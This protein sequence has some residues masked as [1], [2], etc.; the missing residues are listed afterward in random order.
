MGPGVK[1]VARFGVAVAL[2]A[3]CASRSAPA[4]RTAD[5]AAAASAPLAACPKRGKASRFREMTWAEYYNDVRERA[6]R[7]AATIIWITPPNVRK[8]R[9]KPPS[10]T[11]A[12]A[13]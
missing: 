13:R 12:C 7:N 11:T 9:A 4:P 8:P 1:W 3:G 10:S 6:W 2:L 5:T